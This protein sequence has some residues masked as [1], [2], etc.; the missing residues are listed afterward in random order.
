MT[1]Q[2]V[3]AVGTFSL[4]TGFIAIA[5]IFLAKRFAV[6]EDPRLD[7]VEQMLPAANCG[8]CGYAGCRQFAEALLSQQSNPGQCTVSEQAQRE[9]IA[10]F[11][12][13]DVGAVNQL[14]AR[15]ACAGGNNVARFKANYSGLE[16]CRA[17]SLV[18]G[19]AK[20]CNWGCLGLG[21]CAQVCDYD[22]IEMSVNQ[23]PMVSEVLCTGCGDCVDACPKDLFSI[24][25][26]DHR[27][28]VACNNPVFGDS[29]LD[30]CEV[31]CTACARCEMDASDKLVSMNSN[32]P[33]VD[34]AKQQSTD[35][36]QRCP[37]GAIIW[38][39]AD[40]TVEYGKQSKKILRTK[41]LNY[42]T[43]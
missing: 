21:D 43:S 35:A 7:L 42:Q 27:L 3:T 18:A 12:Q 37:T 41:A 20:V 11:L 9:L 19:G 1:T 15:L 10:N 33:V 40:G 36:I 6:D 30:Y 5:L 17:A 34:Y 25:P 16:S 4:L 14:V 28:W 29:L 39:H 23:L 32:L 2:L 22:A 24:H 13:T 26:I 8:A 31:A 38:V